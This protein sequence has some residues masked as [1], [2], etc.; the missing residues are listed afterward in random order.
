MDGVADA[1]AL[2]AVPA[3]GAAAPAPAAARTLLRPIVEVAAI[4]A[5]SRPGSPAS[6][7]SVPSELF[8]AVRAKE[9]GQGAYLVPAHIAMAA[10][11]SVTG[12]MEVTDYNFNSTGGNKLKK[13]L[14]QR[15]SYEQ[16]G[17]RS[18]CDGLQLT[19][20]GQALLA[21]APTRQVYRA[22]L[23]CSGQS[24]NSKAP[25]NCQRAC[26]GIGVCF[27]GCTDSRD[28]H[29]SCAFRIEITASLQDVDAGRF[30]VQ[31]SGTHVPEGT[32]H[33]PPPPDGL[34][35]LPSVISALTRECLGGSTP[36]VAV[37]NTAANLG[38]GGAAASTR[39]VPL[40][41]TVS[42]RAKRE[43]RKER[44][45][46]T[47]DISR[48]DRLVRQHLIQR[49]YVLYYIPGEMLVLSTPFLLEHARCDGQDMVVSDAKVDTAPDTKWS[50]IRA[51][52]T[53]EYSGR[54]VPLV[55]WISPKENAH[56]VATGAG[57]LRNAVA[58]SEP[59]CDHRFLF[60]FNFDGQQGFKMTRICTPYFSPAVCID[61]HMP[62]F[63]GFQRAL[64]GAIFLCD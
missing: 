55:V 8:S 50:S 49:Q 37:N 3:V 45:G 15:L 62:S 57:A 25:P 11:M 2:A 24:L 60:H 48:I 34:K 6:P 61:K 51:K 54:T 22:G 35:A 5:T 58:C 30:H 38:E 36:T 46:T 18:L 23:A 7:D 9:M 42:G 40:A 52:S 29:H 32:V 13:D 53:V 4:S 56:T 19:A 41:S 31:V 1:A 33:V 59:N 17:K 21:T 47:D 14:V 10:F 26:G 39:F 27:H 12:P 44:G 16:N 63:R 28:R 20:A 43:R 64:Y